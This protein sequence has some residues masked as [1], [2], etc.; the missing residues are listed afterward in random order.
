MI[1]LISTEH[2]VIPPLYTN[3]VE[4]PVE[5]FTSKQKSVISY[6]TLEDDM[7]DLLTHQLTL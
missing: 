5:C 6:S 4:N 7:I 1:T 3:G 2:Q